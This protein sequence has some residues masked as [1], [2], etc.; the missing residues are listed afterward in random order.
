MNEVSDLIADVRAAQRVYLI[1]NGG[2]AANAIHIA[3]DLISCGVKAHALTADVAT[4][5]AIANDFGY[6]N[7]FAR[8]IEVFGEQGDVLIAL[9]GSGNSPNI[10]RGIEVARG[11]GMKTWAL[12][13]IGAGEAPRYAER[14]IATG[15]SM[16]TAE[17]AQIV[18]GHR[19]MKALR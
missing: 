3:N 7:V 2:S 5:T 11:K 15:E 17:D 18:I 13:G 4:L 16:Q 14:H 8:Q 6:E 12:V 19:V 9:S 1:G 10:L